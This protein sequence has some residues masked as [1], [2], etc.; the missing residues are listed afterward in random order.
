MSKQLIL[1]EENVHV[2]VLAV[3]D[4]MDPRLFSEVLGLALDRMILHTQFWHDVFSVKWTV[5]FDVV[6][7]VHVIDLKIYNSET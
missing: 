6:E 3:V 5:N 7:V 1:G 2:I 4:F